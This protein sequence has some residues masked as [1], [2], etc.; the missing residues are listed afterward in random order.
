MTYPLTSGQPLVAVLT[1]VHN[2][3]DSLAACLESVRAQ[4][5]RDWIHLV[6]D[7]ASTDATREIAGSFAA[8]D[9]RVRVLSFRE[10]LPMFENFNRALL[11]VPSEARYLKQLHAD[12]TL[13]PDCLT[14]MVVA[15]QNA[16]DVALVVS[17]FYQ[18]STLSPAR[19][20]RR[21]VRLPGRMVAKGT[22]LGTSNMLG[23]PSVP[24]MRIDRLA[25]WPSLFRVDRYPPGHPDTPP[26]NQADKESCLDTLARSDIAFLP[27]PLVYLKDGS[28]SA[29]GFARR[30]AGWHATRL[31][32]L[33]RRGQDFMDEKRLRK[34]IRRTTRKWARAIAWRAL[35]RLRR[36]DQ[37]FLLYQRLCLDDLIPRLRE[38]GCTREAKL[39]D[40]WIRPLIG[41]SR[42]SDSSQLHRPVS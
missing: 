20:P 14:K 17:R 34:G 10:L 37:E 21:A 4:T 5:Y 24:L 9:A 42:A 11:A 12:D 19:A 22:V 2:G 16:P 31:D 33:L 25:G 6:V 7:N 30:V 28:P 41:R 18:G 23:S 26:H 27:E 1:P 8:K 39:L 29:T 38:A 15:A 3:A 32:L 35:K 36:S 13:H 40:R